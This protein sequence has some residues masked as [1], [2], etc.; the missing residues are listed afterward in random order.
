MDY[1]L[2]DGLL[3]VCGDAIDIKNRV[4]L[5]K[6]VTNVV[7][8]FIIFEVICPKHQNNILCTHQISKY[9]SKYDT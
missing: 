4:G 6:V 5:L 9:Y 8:R 1:R 7:P 3:P 2:P